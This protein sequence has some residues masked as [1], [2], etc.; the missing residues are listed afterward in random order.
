V[1]FQ[2]FETPRENEDEIQTVLA[3]LR[4]DT[5]SALILDA[6]VLEYVTGTNEASASTKQQA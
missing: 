2:L 3:A 1:H 4:S 6:P 5:Y